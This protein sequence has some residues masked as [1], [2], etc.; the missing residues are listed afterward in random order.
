[1]FFKFRNNKKPDVLEKRDR[2]TPIP[3]NAWRT[4]N[5]DISQETEE[6]CLTEARNLD[7]AR[8]LKRLRS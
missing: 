1:M 7:L 5:D 4:A 6:Q 3:F 2:V 8:Q